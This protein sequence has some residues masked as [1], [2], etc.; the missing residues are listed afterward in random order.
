MDLHT[1]IHNWSLQPFSQDYGLA[2]HITHVVCV[3]FIHEWGT[4]SLTSTTND[5]FFE[6]IFHGRCIY[7]QTFCQKSA[8]RKTPKIYCFSYF[9]LTLELGYEPGLYV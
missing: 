9:V 3:N 4:F 1:Y 5:R 2:A 7:S 8:E 6:E